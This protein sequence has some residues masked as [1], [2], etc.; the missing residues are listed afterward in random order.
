MAVYRVYLVHD[1]GSLEPDESFYCRDD[2]E[3]VGK[4]LPP[5]RDD[6]C[7]ELWQGGRFIARA[8]RTGPRPTERPHA[9]G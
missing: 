4:L 7:A 9:T 1:D 8:A 2:T 3:A 6:V 5:A